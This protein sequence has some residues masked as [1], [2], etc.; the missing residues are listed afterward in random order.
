M[1]SGAWRATVYG[2]A[3]VGQTQQRQHHRLH[4]VEAW[5]QAQ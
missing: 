4:K 5:K 3:R 2:V 1:D